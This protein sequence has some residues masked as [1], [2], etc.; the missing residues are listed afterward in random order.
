VEPATDHR[1]WHAFP[2]RRRGLTHTAYL[3]RRDSFDTA[4][5][6]FS[7]RYADQNQQDHEIFVDAIRSGALDAHEGV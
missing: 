3:G 4:I 7:R 1:R 6:E 5:A 2:V